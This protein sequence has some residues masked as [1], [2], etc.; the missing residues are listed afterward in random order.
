MSIKLNP[1]LTCFARTSQKGNTF[2]AGTLDDGRWLH[3]FK[4]RGNSS[5]LEIYED[6][7]KV[8]ALFPKESK[9]TGKKY[10][11]GFLGERDRYVTAFLNISKDKRHKYISI[12]EQVEEDEKPIQPPKQTKPKTKLKKEAEDELEF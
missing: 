7:E 5:V 12:Y 8:G 11:S 3:I 2:Y 1:I 9:G 4:S 10:Y 6:R